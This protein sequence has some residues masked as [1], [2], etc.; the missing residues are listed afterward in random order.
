MFCSRQ[1]FLLPHF[2]PLLA[3]QGLGG[4]GIA[5]LAAIILS[6]LVSLQERGAFNGLM[7]MYAFPGLQAKPF[8]DYFPGLGL[9][10][11]ASVLLLAVHLLNMINGG[12]QSGCHFVVAV[13]KL[14]SF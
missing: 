1:C 9:L 6:D 5:A 13:Y 10:P 2:V 11:V 4:G 8:I 12:T 7:G 14:C 3:V